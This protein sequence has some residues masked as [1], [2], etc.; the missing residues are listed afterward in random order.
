MNAQKT[1]VNISL[2]IAYPLFLRGFASLLSSLGHHVQS[3]HESGKELMAWL[4]PS[5]L[6]EIVFLDVDRQATEALETTALLQEH[7]PLIK[8][9][10][11]SLNAEKMIIRL[12]MRIGAAGYMY[13]EAD[14]HEVNA[15]VKAVITKGFYFPPP[16]AKRLHGRYL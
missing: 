14:L 4:S 6:P 16:K 10:A 11:L 12:L 2:V 8:V 1:R 3:S 9:V 5:N 7:H 15:A 13:K